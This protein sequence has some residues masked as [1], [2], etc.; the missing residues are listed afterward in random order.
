MFNFQF[1]VIISLKEHRYLVPREFYKTWY[2]WD[3][4][5]NDETNN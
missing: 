3:E 1:I 2:E 4:T 5:N